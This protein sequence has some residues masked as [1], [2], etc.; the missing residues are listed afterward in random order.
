MIDNAENIFL[1]GEDITLL[2][3]LQAIAGRCGATTRVITGDTP[4]YLYICFYSTQ[5]EEEMERE[6]T[7]LLPHLKREYVR[8]VTSNECR[9]HVSVEGTKERPV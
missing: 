5:D 4:M 2:K 7:R 6:V 9:T 3:V 8:G 1:Y